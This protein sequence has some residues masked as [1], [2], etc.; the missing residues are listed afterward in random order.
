MNTNSMN[1]KKMTTNAILIAAGAILHQ[2]T[3]AIPL[4]GISMQPDL[5][6]AMLFIIMIYNKDYKTNL[7]CGV[8]VG[9][10][11]ALTTK[12]PMGQI[13]NIVDKI[14]TTNIMFVL[15]TA[16]R[17]KMSVNKLMAIALPVGTMISGTMFVS[18]A[19]IIGGIQ[20]DLFLGM[21]G[22]VVIP[23][24]VVNTVL[25]FVLFKI[26]EKTAVTTGAYLAN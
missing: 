23:A 3:P 16:L 8:A 1:I 14:V 12:M 24:A 22:T 2:I 9:V 7:I 25:G 17:N 4:L 20:A 6:L 19:V 26:V 10:F 15:I 13:P 21:V 18:V 11:A 5:S